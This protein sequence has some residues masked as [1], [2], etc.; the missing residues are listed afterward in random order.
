MQRFLRTPEEIT[1]ALQNQ[2][3]VYINN[4]DNQFKLINDLVAPWEG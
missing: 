1:K 2:K 3:V 4:D